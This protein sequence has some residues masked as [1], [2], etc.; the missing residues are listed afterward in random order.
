MSVKKK[1]VTRAIIQATMSNIFSALASVA[2]R[3]RSMPTIIFGYQ[4]DSVSRTAVKFRNHVAA[5]Q[6]PLPILITDGEK[7]ILL[8]AT[9]TYN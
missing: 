2:C 4:C 5:A 6:H 3:I 7:S 9:F 8:Y 1:P